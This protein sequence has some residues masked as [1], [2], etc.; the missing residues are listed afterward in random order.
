MQKKN[1]VTSE[2]YSDLCDIVERAW[3]RWPTEHDKDDKYNHTSDYARAAAMKILKILNLKLDV[4]DITP[5]RLLKMR[6]T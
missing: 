2:Q 4:S 1:L 5:E 3:H 6:N